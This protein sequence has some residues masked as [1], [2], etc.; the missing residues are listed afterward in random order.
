VQH[1]QGRW[2]SSQPGIGTAHPHSQRTE[3]AS[4]DSIA[5]S[6]SATSI[7]PRKPRPLP[8]PFPLPGRMSSVPLL[9]APY[10]VSSYHVQ[11]PSTHPLFTRLPPSGT[12]KGQFP[13]P[14][15]FSHVTF[16]HQPTVTPPS[17][18]VGSLAFA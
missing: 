13:Y 8:D 6:H 11:P 18:P 1:E 9:S 15:S 10:F 7:L 2:P 12:R 16:P 4:R 14:L 17:S 3:E 5:S